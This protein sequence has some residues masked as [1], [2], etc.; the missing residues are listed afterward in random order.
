MYVD[1]AQPQACTRAHIGARTRRNN[2]NLYKREIPKSWT[3]IKRHVARFT[4]VKAQARFRVSRAQFPVQHARADT[5]WSSQGHTI[6]GALVLDFV[7]ERGIRYAG[8]VYTSLTRTTDLG[9]VEVRFLLASRVY[10]VWSVMCII[11]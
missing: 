2:A 10:F 11:C 9:D 5:A 4:G 7:T 3:P 6:Y 1:P 8:L